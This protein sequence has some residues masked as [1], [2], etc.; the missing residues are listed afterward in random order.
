MANYSWKEIQSFNFTVNKILF[1]NNMFVAV[2]DGGNIRTSNDGIS[3]A[4][5]TTGL[6]GSVRLNAVTFGGGVWVVVGDYGTILSSTD[7]G[8]T[9][10]SSG[11]ITTNNMHFTDVDFGNNIF[12][13]VS[14]GGSQDS[15]SHGP[16]TNPIH[17]IYCSTLSGNAIGAWS[18]VQGSNAITS[19]LGTTPTLI[20]YVRYSRSGVSSPWLAGRRGVG[21]NNLQ[22]IYRNNTQPTTN[23]S[24]P[25]SGIF[26]NTVAG[27]GVLTGLFYVDNNFYILSRR[28][29]GTGIT[30]LG[31][32]EARVNM[33]DPTTTTP[34]PTNNF[35]SGIN[36]DLHQMI[37]F[38]GQ[39]LVVGN[40]GTML[41]STGPATYVDYSDRPS[42]LTTQNLLTAAFG[43]DNL[44]IAGE[45]GVSW[46]RTEVPNF[47][48]TASSNPTE[49]GTISGTGN[50]PQN[51]HIN[52]IATPNSNFRHVRWE[53]DGDFAGGSPTL[54][55]IV[56]GDA[57]YTAIFADSTIKP[58]IL[59]N[60]SLQE[61]VYNTT[62][63]DRRIEALNIVDA[64]QQKQINSLLGSLIYLGRIEEANPN[65]NQLTNRALEILAQKGENEILLGHTLVDLN[66]IDW[67][68]DG[69]SEWINVGNSNVDLS[70]ISIFGSNGLTGGGNLTNSPLHIGL[71][72]APGFHVLAGPA[73]L[74][75]PSG[76]AA[77]RP[78]T[79]RDLTGGVSSNIP[80][81]GSFFLRM[82]DSSSS[83]A[84][85]NDLRAPRWEQ[86][87]S[88]NNGGMFFGNSLT[89]D[90]G[91]NAGNNLRLN[92]TGSGVTVS[93]STGSE[94]E[95]IINIEISPPSAPETPATSTALGTVRF[96]NYTALTSTI[97]SQ[98]DNT[99][100][101][102]VYPVRPVAITSGD[103]LNQMV[104]GVPTAT[105]N[106]LG[107]V[108]AT[109][110]I[111]NTARVLAQTGGATGTLGWSTSSAVNTA[112]LYLRT[113]TGGVLEWGALPVISV[114][115]NTGVSASTSAGAVT[116]SGVTVSSTVPGIVPTTGT[117][118]GFKILTAAGM[119][120]PAWSAAT[121]ANQ[122]LR[123][124]G[125]TAAGW[126]TL[127]TAAI[128]SNTT[129][130]QVLTAV[131]G[132][133][134]TWATST[135]VPSGGGL[136]QFLRGP[137]GGA[138]DN[139]LS[140]EFQAGVDHATDS[141]AS[142]Q[143]NSICFKNGTSGNGNWLA[144]LNW[145]NNQLGLCTSAGILR[146][147]GGNS[148]TRRVQIGLAGDEAI[149]NIDIGN[150]S[151]ATASFLRRAEFVSGLFT[152][153]IQGGTADSIGQLTMGNIGQYTGIN[154]GTVLV[155]ANGGTNSLQLQS[156]NGQVQIST[157][158]AGAS[159]GLTIN[160]GSA[161]RTMIFEAEF[162][163]PTN[164]SFP[165]FVSTQV[166]WAQATGLGTG[167]TSNNFIPI[168]GRI[169]NLN[170]T[171]SAHR[172]WW[173][174]NVGWGDEGLCGWGGAFMSSPD[175]QPHNTTIRISYIRRP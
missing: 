126:G 20:R 34:A 97:V 112:N 71:D 29:T 137:S 93:S 159:Q 148:G 59:T 141:R 4:Q 123:T 84:E 152:T 46:V 79:N 63:I 76:T 80:G 55:I 136:H 30:E 16:P 92:F 73:E 83:T 111:A 49:G 60:L 2:G 107:L 131:N 91:A 38:N 24:W 161:I 70:N 32:G 11:S 150:D 44:V 122:V 56:T 21:L 48:I 145:V 160:G 6:S 69:N 72:S 130:T 68:W 28:S 147:T 127:P 174:F 168:A 151:S 169:R 167:L 142:I 119:A 9:W 35:N 162:I 62:A 31:V 41:I 172:G 14:T 22:Q 17:A 115:G 61:D 154:G 175:G 134:P 64:N 12:V 100:T 155:R 8:N 118:T 42:G 144:G 58:R 102:A 65:Q 104:V 39:R 108:P 87:I 85:Q 89:P 33:I 132:G 117:G 88:A 77:A 143:P 109:A 129:G 96:A 5:I 124:T 170:A 99:I 165:N 86:N 40:N 105:V 54:P 164:P 19:A 94:S 1:A 47:L 120:T 114:A 18:F 57:H 25:Q 133:A 10:S 135:T 27:I 106:A 121:A 74:G 50:F 173:H 157:A 101:G 149:F 103:T 156:V 128:A 140:S 23:N 138:W 75:S 110:H 51:S 45:S 37:A 15:A 81:T 7:N 153:N 90:W 53:K 26:P 116:V 158:I 66:N 95:R 78:L 43:N 125:A 146:L 139:R 163:P 36:H 82:G 113:A 52:L 171:N 3:W 67:R 166:T 13:A 98:A